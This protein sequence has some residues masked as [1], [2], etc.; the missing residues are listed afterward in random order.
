MASLA[1][2]PWLPVLAV[3]LLAALAYAGMHASNWAEIRAHPSYFVSA[4][5]PLLHNLDGYYFLRLARET[6][7]G[8][9]GVED[10]LREE[11]RPWLPPPL[12][13]LDLATAKVSGTTFEQAAF[14]LPPILGALVFGVLALFGAV[15]RRPM[16]APLAGLATVTASFWHTRTALGFFD[17]DCLNSVFM[18]LGPM[19]IYLFVS[20][21]RR[22]LV[23]LGLGL[24]CLGFFVWWWPQGGLAV[25]GLTG[26]AY[27]LSFRLPSSRTEK[28]A[29]LLLLA[30][31]A[32]ALLLL[33]L[34]FAGLATSGLGLYKDILAHLRLISGSGGEAE[35]VGRSVQEL[36]PML[37]SA[38]F[39]DLSANPVAVIVAEVG[40]LAFIALKRGPALFLLPLLVF[41]CASVF[42]ARFLIFAAL[43]YGVGYGAFHTLLTERVRLL[44]ESA[45]AGPGLA[46]VLV[47]LLVPSYL[48]AAHQ[49][50]VP[51]LDAGDHALAESLEACS[52]PGSLAWAWW[53]YGYFLQE[54]ADRPTLADGGSASDDAVFVLAFP[55]AAED[56]EVAARWMRFFSSHGLWGYSVLSERLKDRQAVAAFLNNV[57]LNPSQ[58]TELAAATG[59]PLERDWREF[60]LP[61]VETYLYLNKDTLNL[62]Y[63]WLH[64]GRPEGLKEG[65]FIIDRLPLDSLSIENS[66][67]ILRK[68]D[69]GMGQVGRVVDVRQTTA[70]VYPNSSGA[71][72][73]AV[74]MR[75]EEV[76]YLAA[77]RLVKTVAFRLLFN[78]DPALDRSFELVAGSPGKGGVW[79]VLPEV[80]RTGPDSP[81]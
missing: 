24:A 10:P 42:S 11:P 68:P 20:R 50:S 4:G 54:V 79:R 34:E 23:F 48:S 7:E 14:L 28:T 62:A 47:L 59:F 74:L 31:L 12:S 39:L 26:L 33:L 21:P 44:R 15:L 81:R 71:P 80:R 52:P 60:L 19:L 53:D 51:P 36:R 58:A 27:A 65:E 76:A 18:L 41:A 38:I 5:R 29:K 64:L 25:A 73:T 70:R 1:A 69:G 45:W 55:L 17:T 16:F 78:L 3:W 66:T 35:V 46:L 57:F 13:L 2:R 56:G 61:Q 43:A 9:Y 32:G 67:G 30:A 49:E 37:L 40:L 72:V 8:T 6:G 22:R 77:E 75:S 63:W